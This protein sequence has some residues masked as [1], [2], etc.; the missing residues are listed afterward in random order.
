MTLERR[1][2]LCQ[3]LFATCNRFIA[4]LTIPFYQHRSYISQA[5]IFCLAYGLFIQIPSQMSGRTGTFQQLCF[6][7]NTCLPL[8]YVCY[9]LC[10]LLLNAPLLI[11]VSWYFWIKGVLMGI[12]KVYLLNM[13]VAVYTA[14]NDFKQLYGWPY[15]LGLKYPKSAT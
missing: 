1:K 9:T 11:C 6:W 10:Q 2:S 5:F 7:L 8:F 14:D 3:Y 13:A 12:L 15:L 4:T